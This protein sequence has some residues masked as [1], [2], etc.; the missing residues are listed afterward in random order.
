M[1]SLIETELGF[2]YELMMRGKDVTASLARFVT[3][4]SYRDNIAGEA[5]EFEVELDNVDGRWQREWYPAKGDLLRGKL[6]RRG[7]PLLD[8]G[9]FEVDQ[10]RFSAPP[11]VVMIRAL[12]AGVRKPVRTREAKAY[13][14]TTLAAIVAR[15]AKKNHL[16]VVGK[17]A[18]IK[19][20]RVTQYMER[21]VAFLT[22]LAGEYGYVFKIVA[23]R[24][25]FSDRQALRE[26]KASLVLTPEQLSS[27]EF[28]DQ[29]KDV[30][31][32][33]SMRRYDHDKKALAQTEI[34]DDGSDEPGEHSSGDT[35]RLTGRLG[36][37]GMADRRSKA[38]LAAAKEDKLTASI[39]L[40]GDQRIIAGLTL[41]LAGFGKLDGTYLIDRASHTIQ[42]SSGY[43]TSAE[44]KRV[45]KDG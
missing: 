18:P 40:A 21:D 22:R 14:N 36:T 6:G 30:P 43:S 17:I 24:I 12:S 27:Y 26:Q 28:C 3:R 13:E 10:I 7:L 19:I 16:K 38:A 23:G 44:I 8:C 15:I 25:V 31:R 37:N 4:L 1:A 20:D 9:S 34:A 2:D 11:S 39:S 5:E 42:R 32:A 41:A 33:V 45:R 35:L 29:I